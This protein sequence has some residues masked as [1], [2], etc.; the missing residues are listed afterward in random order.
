MFLSL[1]FLK[2]LH[3]HVWGG[4]DVLLSKD[5]FYQVILFF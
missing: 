5:V 2:F 1:G 4:G 3:I